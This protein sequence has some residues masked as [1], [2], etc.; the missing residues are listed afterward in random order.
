M[1]YQ[2]LAMENPLLDIQC[3]DA[4]EMLQKYQLKANDAILAAESHMSLYDEIISKYEVVYVAGGAAQ[5]TAR[6]AQYFLPPNSTVYI[7]CVSNDKNAETL[8]AAAAADGLRTVYQ[9][10]TECPTGTCAVLLTGHHRSLV[11]S[12]GAAEKFTLDFLKKPENWAIVE[13]AKYY[14]VGSFFMTHDGGRDAALAVSKHAAEQNK[15]FA[16]NLSAPF[17]S[18]FFK[19]RLD[20][21]VENADILFGNE[22]E[23]RTYSSVAGWNTDDV[24]EI[25]K[26]L[27]NLPKGNG[28]PRTVVITQGAQETVVA[29]G[30]SVQVFPVEK[31]E[32]KDIV[33]TNGAGDAFCGGFMGLYAQGVTDVARCVKAGH[34]LASICIKN[35]GPTF[36]KPE[37]R[38]P[39]PK[40]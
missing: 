36:P 31:I 23:A 34:Y 6:G 11:T 22:D 40:F 33:D 32:D 35:V 21:V 24:K 7:G 30:D 37:D 14:Y 9:T 16:L 10:S 26:K 38:E 2:L 17:I 12:L 19:D 13:N 3:R 15:T 27:A 1:S 18:Q 5:N 8:K 4:E 29:V 28:R 20:A 25:A 39:L